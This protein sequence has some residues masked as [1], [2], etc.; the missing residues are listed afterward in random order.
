MRF[1][2]R[3]C[4]LTQTYRSRPYHGCHAIFGQ[5]SLLEL[6]SVIEARDPARERA[7][8]TVPGAA[9]DH[10]FHRV[11]GRAALSAAWRKGFLVRMASVFQNLP[12]RQSLVCGR[13]R[14]RMSQQWLRSADDR[15]KKTTSTKTSSLQRLRLRPEYP[16]LPL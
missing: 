3:R 6:E 9:F 13:P 7:R 11:S 12:V 8:E 15:K 1:M 10:C 5:S 14:G 16:L 4:P 2:E